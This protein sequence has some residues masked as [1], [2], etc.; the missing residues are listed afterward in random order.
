MS[1]RTKKLVSAA[2][3]VVCFGVLAGVFAARGKQNKAEEK[4][5]LSAPVA[6]AAPVVSTPEPTPEPTLVPT[7]PIP[8]SEAGNF[9]VYGRNFNIS[10]SVVNL[11]HVEVGD[12]GA[13]IAS[14]L[15]FMPNLKILD[16]DTCGVDS[17]HMAAI[18]DANPG[19][20]VIWRIWFGSDKAYSVRT[21]VERI[22]ASNSGPGTPG[23]VFSREDCKELGYCTKVKLLDVGHT[24]SIA[25]ISFVANMPDLE[26]AILAMAVWCD[27]TP[28]ASCPKLEYAELQTTGL[29]DLTPLKECKNLKHLNICH[30]FGIHDITP[31]YDLDLARLWI[32]PFDPIPTEQIDEFARLHPDCKINTTAADPTI[33]GWRTYY[34]ESIGADVYDPR[35]ELLRS[36]FEYGS[37]GDLVH[38]S[39]SF[40]WNDPYYDQPKEY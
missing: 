25:D 37:G 29:S 5:E 7:P 35:Y 16:M 17:E 32:G 1:T 27:A 19:V 9:S 23:G 2:A 12:D 40:K 34:D 36:Q 24:E 26:A 3:L 18:R 39:Y 28:L 22:L 6:T 33:E 4:P 13:A 38:G 8:V 20:E 11:S 15:P 30:N 14:M 10:D 21:D 31:L